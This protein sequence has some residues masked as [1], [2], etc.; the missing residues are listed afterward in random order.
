MN[1]ME[2]QKQIKEA[3]ERNGTNNIKHVIFIM[4]DVLGLVN[5]SNA[6]CEI[7][8]SGRHYNIT[9]F[10]LLQHLKTGLSNPL[11]RGNATFIMVTKF[12]Y[13]SKELIVDDVKNIIGDNKLA[14]QF[15]NNVFKVP[16]LFIGMT[17]L[18]DQP[19]LFP[20]SID[21]I[22]DNARRIR[23]DPHGKKR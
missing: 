20:I 11:I 17:N 1:L 23:R 16:Y 6:L 5:K 19:D 10:L 21:D 15:V 12:T 18:L 2:S 13:S 7:F 9:T 22:I 8:A 4:D 14:L 3:D